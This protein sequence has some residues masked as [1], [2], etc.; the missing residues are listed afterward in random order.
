MSAEIGSF[1]RG[2]TGNATVVLNGSFTPSV[3]YFWV[4]ARSSTN[5]TDVR[6]SV[7]AAD[8]PN[9]LQSAMATFVGAANK[10]TRPTTSKCIMHYR[11]NA[12]ATLVLDGSLVSAS[13]GDFTVNMTTV[14]S[15]YPIYFIAIE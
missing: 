1:S 10:G 13:P 12:G 15:N 4:G 6:F 9:S 8:F 14:D 11:D 7:G 2:S 3:V 5:E